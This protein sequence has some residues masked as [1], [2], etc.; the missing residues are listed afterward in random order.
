MNRSSTVSHRQSPSLVQYFC[1]SWGRGLRAFLAAS[2]VPA[3]AVWA[4]DPAPPPEEPTVAKA[5]NEGQQ[6]LQ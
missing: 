2:L 4:V 5:S 3:A 6:A 1:M